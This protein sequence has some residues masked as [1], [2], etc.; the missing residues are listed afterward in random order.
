[1]CRPYGL[2][3]VDEPFSGL[4]RTGR[5]TFIDLL[6]QIRDDGGSVLV[7]THDPQAMEVFDRTVTLEQGVIVDDTRA[8]AG[9]TGVGEEETATEGRS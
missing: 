5:A 1:M 3:L 7:A 9:T 6:R 4:D 8:G 2:L